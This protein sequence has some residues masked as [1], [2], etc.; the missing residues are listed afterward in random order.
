MSVPQVPTL[1][2]EQANSYRRL[3]ARVIDLV[4]VF[5]ALLIISPLISFFGY[6]IT[7]KKQVSDVGALLFFVFLVGLV[8]AYDAV[9]HRLWGKTLGKK[10]LGMRVVDI[11]GEK[12]GWGMSILRSIVLYISGVV[13][14]FLIFVTI[15]I[16]GWFFIAGLKKYR[17][18]PH[19][20]M[21]KSYVV[22]E[23]R[24]QLKKAEIPIGTTGQALVGPAADL[25]KLHE[26]GFITDEE[27]ERKSKEIAK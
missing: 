16:F 1:E 22:M 3:G 25:Y 27:Y 9:A 19:E 26:Q 4:I 2:Y 23:S 11:K 8:I 12:L 24:G 10:L 5:F 6:L 7:S 15:S 18:F 17:R 13:I 21:S 20:S 14:V